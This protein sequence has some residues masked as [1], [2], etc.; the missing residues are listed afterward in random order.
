MVCWLVRLWAADAALRRDAFALWVSFVDRRGHKRGLPRCSPGGT[1]GRKR[2][3]GIEPSFPS[4]RRHKLLFTRDR[5][6]I[7]QQ[8][9]VDYCSESDRVAIL[10]NIDDTQPIF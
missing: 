5:C 8:K 4:L 3:K 6:D 2:V 1:S 9:T 7:E 10:K